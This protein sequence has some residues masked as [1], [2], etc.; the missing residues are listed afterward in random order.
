MEEN[1]EWWGTP[2]VGWSKVNANPSPLNVFCC[3]K[4][5]DGNRRFGI[6]DYGTGS[7]ENHPLVA[8]DC[9]PYVCPN[10]EPWEIQPGS[11]RFYASRSLECY[12]RDCIP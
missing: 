1:Y 4:A 8:L 7:F 6:E 3:W 11:R 5:G 10:M 9:Y 12:V 2:M